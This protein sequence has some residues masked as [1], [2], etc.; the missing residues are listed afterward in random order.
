MPLR[1][2]IVVSLAFSLRAP[3]FAQLTTGNIQGTIV[4]P[5]HAVIQGAQVTVTNE[6][7]RV[8]R[9][10]TSDSSGIFRAIELAPGDYTVAVEA[11]GF[12]VFRVQK[13]PVRVGTTT[14]SDVTLA[15][16]S[17]QQEITVGEAK[18][19]QVDTISTT[20]GSTIPQEKIEELAVVSRSVIDLAQLEPGVQIRDGGEVDGT[21]NNFMVPSVQGRSGQE[22]R[23]EWDGLSIQDSSVGGPTVNISL[24]AVQEFQVA[25]ATSSPSMSVASS[26]AVNIISRTG[27]NTFH[28]SGFGFFRDDRLGASTAGIKLPYDRYQAGFRFGGP[29]LRNKLYFFTNFEKNNSR[30]SFLADPPGF[31]QFKTFFPKPFRET[32][33]MG[34]LDGTVSKHLTAFARYSYSYNSGVVGRPPVGGSRLDG[35]DN[36]TRANIVAAGLS[37]AGTNWTHSWRFSYLNFFE[38]AVPARSLPSPTDSLGRPFLLQID[39]GSVLAMGPAFLTNQVEKESTYQGKYDVGRA[40]KSHTFRFG[41]DFTRWTTLGAF[42]LLINGPQIGTSSF[43]STSSN[44]LEYPL[45]FALL[46]NAQGYLSEK[47]AL[48]YPHGGTFNFRPAFY[49]HDTWRAL[50]NLSINFGLRYQWASDIV[51]PDLKRSPLL[52]EFIPGL[53]RSTETPKTNFGPEFGIAWD[54]TK[55]GKTVVRSAV[56]VH[57]EE[58]TNNLTSLDR[59][60]NI[61][62]GI[63]LGFAFLAGGLPLVDPRTGNPFPPGDPLATQFGFPN[64]TSGAVLAPIFGQPIG[65]AAKQVNDLSLLFQAS[66]A[67]AARSFPSGPT[68]FEL[69]REI[70]LDKQF[71]LGVGPNPKTPHTFQFTIGVEREL[72]S[73]LKLTAEY[74]KIRG[75]NYGLASELNGIGESV[76]SSFDRPAAIAAITTTNAGFGCPADATPASI[77]CAIAAGARMS[78]FGNNGLGKGPGFQ[79]F[80]FRGKNPDFGEMQFLFFGATSNYNALNIRLETRSG[81][82]GWKPFSWMKANSLTTTYTLSR[83]DGVVKNTGI[84]AVADEGSFPVPWDNREPD[85]FRGPMTLDRTHI[86]NVATTTEIKAGFRA[87][88]MAHWFTALSQSPTLPAALGGCDGGASEI[89]CSDVTGDGTIGDLLPTAVRPGSFGRDLKGAGGLN[90]AISSYNT[91]HGGQPSPAGQLV[92]DQGLFTSA[93]LQALGGVM[94][95]IPLAPSG[96][97]G[98]DPVATLDLRISWSGK[99]WKER[100]S[101]EPV[102][103]IFNVFN[104]THFDPPGNLL[105]GSLTG[106]AGHINGTIQDQ[107]TN[108]RQRG[109]GVFEQGAKRQIQFGL[110]IT[111]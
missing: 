10:V 16:G 41:A 96:Q 98:L 75:L 30:D 78:D 91:Q 84:T 67:E 106:T 73:G 53:S 32:F 23:I 103:D 56:A 107:R 111:F 58:S 90:G 31:P 50:P 105:A 26:G 47:P 27:S 81:P 70:S 65:D 100:I 61:P 3:V 101:V 109:S 52:D 21:K 85:S 59:T 29:L 12:R 43:S 89:F 35:F 5:S 49:F 33:T 8:S 71:T 95:L 62:P 45:E 39:G 57:Y 1:L 19:V 92:V 79:G 87:S 102:A 110:R 38:N 18:Q 25:T 46:G 63:G 22:T 40:Y 54:P 93:Q 34:R 99:F 82:V 36:K 51:D 15:V 7:T 64:G 17:V 24:D 4:D 74:V 66:V 76:S 88:L 69:T 55:D 77:N 6:A 9:K 14:Q 104:R 2:I 83:K 20:V 86:L 11:Q 42:P 108:V 44:P 72:R 94:P 13:V 97:V 28:G 48:G 37:F 60:P 80:A 68:T